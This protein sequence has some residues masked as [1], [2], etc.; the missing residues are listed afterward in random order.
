[1][2]VVMDI[3]AEMEYYEDTTSIQTS[4]RIIDCHLA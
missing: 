3:R 4:P 2:N 1:M